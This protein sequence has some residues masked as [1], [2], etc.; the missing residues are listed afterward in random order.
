MIVAER[1]W[2]NELLTYCAGNFEQMRIRE[3][4]KNVSVCIQFVREIGNEIFKKH[5][6]LK[7]AD[8]IE[9]INCNEGTKDLQR[10]R[11]GGT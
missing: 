4:L 10:K 6:F 8:F 3:T 11:G 2:R 5:G 1:D 7:L 9:R